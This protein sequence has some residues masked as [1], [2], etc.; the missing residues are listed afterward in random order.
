MSGREIDDPVAANGPEGAVDRKVNRN[1]VSE[2]PDTRAADSA[3][4][5]YHRPDIISCEVWE[6]VA[7]VCTTPNAKTNFPACT[8]LSS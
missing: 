3:R 7:A 2:D 5:P 8:T 1:R 4:R 6:A